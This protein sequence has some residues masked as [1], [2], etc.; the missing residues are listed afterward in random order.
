M[1]ATDEGE[2]RLSHLEII[3]DLGRQLPLKLNPSPAECAK[4][5]NKFIWMEIYRAVRDGGAYL[6]PD[7]KK[8]KNKRC[9]PENLDE[10][11]R[12]H[13]YQWKKELAPKYRGIK[14][15]PKRGF[16]LNVAD[17]FIITEIWG[18]CNLLYDY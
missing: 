3:R 7:F 13:W 4:K 18:N 10:F 9:T 2:K 5:S 16:E 12:M 17:R 15:D 6:H 8:K 14:Q 11:K 1:S